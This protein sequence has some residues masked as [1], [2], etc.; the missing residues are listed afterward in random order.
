MI[1]FLAVVSLSA[2]NLAAQFPGGGSATATLRGR[3]QTDEIVV[4]PYNVELRSV[5]DPMGTHRGFTNSMGEFQ[6]QG[7]AE[8]EYQLTISDRLGRP[9]LQQLVHAD[10]SG[11]PIDVRLPSK[12][13]SAAPAG[14]VSFASLSHKVPRKAQHAFDAAEKARKRGDDDAWSRH[15]QE[16]LAIDPQFAPA[17][18]DLGTYYMRHNMFDLALAELDQAAALDSGAASVQINR[19]GCLAQMGRL[20]EAEIAARRAIQLNGGSPRARYTLGLVLANLRKLPGE[21]VD[22]LLGASDA[23]PG[24]RLVA[25]QI[26]LNSGHA[27]DA[28]KQLSR[29]LQTCSGQNCKSVQRSL[30]RLNSTQ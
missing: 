8:G 11:I 25:A 20:D 30:D 6:I 14:S 13:G 15:L 1:K 24:A 29:Y 21:A 28:R 5:S 27:S 3:V 19:A 22:N 23:Y 7:V 16:A 26:L 17:H 4:E 2:L 10:S 9:I 18:N 12:S